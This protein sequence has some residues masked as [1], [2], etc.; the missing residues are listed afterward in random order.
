MQVLDVTLSRAHKIAERLK[1]LMKDSL[2][3][4]E[5]QSEA[6]SFTGAPAPS[7]LAVLSTRGAS[8]LAALT[9]ATSY[10][11]E[12]AKVRSAIARENQKRGID[13]MLADLERLNKL[14]ITYKQVVAATKA[15]GWLP[16]EVA[17]GTFDANAGRYLTV[18]VMRES[19][20]SGEIAQALQGLQSRVIQ[21]SDEIAEANAPRVK[22]ELPDAIARVVTGC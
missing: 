21:L 6:K 17:Q 22:L 7:E 13:R 2:A 11:L 15:E 5:S 10:S 20:T 4:A 16:S 14:I 8:V 1:D 3:D 12:W 19:A 18:N 9:A